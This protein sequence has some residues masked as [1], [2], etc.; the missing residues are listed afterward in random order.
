MMLSSLVRDIYSGLLDLIYPPHCVLCREAGDGYLCPKCSESI[1][2]I[3]PPVC[4]KCGTP[5]ES[6]ICGECRDREYHFERACSAGVFDGVLREAI[7]ALK[8]RNLL[9]VADPLADILVKA[10]PGTG[11]AGTVD[12][13][14]PIPIH[15]SRM[16]DRGFNQSEELA[17]GLA[18]RVGLR[19]ETGVL[20]KARK[21]RHQVDLT[22]DERAVNP[23][24]SFGVR[25]PERIRGKRVLLVDDVFTTGSTLDEAARV[26]LEAGASA[27]RAYT[28]ARSL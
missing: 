1:T 20:Y 17:R 5:C 21:T 18:S 14:V 6:Y 9:A 27:V 15:R 10:F 24:G 2:T 28:L 13:V 19:V 22:I 16:V 25:N 7:H 23:R 11:L 26:L 12:I 8:Y 4:R 3:V